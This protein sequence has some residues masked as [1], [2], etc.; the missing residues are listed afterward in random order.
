LSIV[1]GGAW[2]ATRKA[3][4]PVQPVSP[5]VEPVKVE[6]KLLEV[7][8]STTPPGAKVLR[9]GRTLAET[10]DAI[11]LPPGET[12]DVVLH[13]DGYVDQEITLDPARDRK[14]LV[15]LEKVGGKKVKLSTAP[16]ET[17]EPPKPVYVP[18]PPPKPSDPVG[19]A[20]ERLARS[21]AP[22]TKRMGDLYAGHGNDGGQHSDWWV[23]LEAGRCYDFV[24]TGGDGVERMFVYL[25][26]PRGRRVTDRGEGSPGVSVHY[27]ANA[28]GSYHF[29]AKLAGGRGDFKMGIYTK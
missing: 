21:S 16:P 6:P 15:K 7:L 14:M 12:W 3:Q 9:E 13:K 28:T 8:V 24:T 18:A 26:G 20:V 10:P 29:Q 22:G 23:T 25:W 27:C 11:K 17:P 19:A 2:L 5:P 1:A 4:P